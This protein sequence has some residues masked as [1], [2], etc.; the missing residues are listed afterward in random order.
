M[1]TETL[2]CLLPEMTLVIAAT[3][4]F[5]GGVFVSGR[6]LWSW[7]AVA[8]VLIAGWMLYRQYALLFWPDSSPVHTAIADVEAQRKAPNEPSPNYP[9]EPLLAVAVPGPLAIDL[10]SQYVRWLVLVVG[11]G[12]CSCQRGLRRTCRCPSMWERC[13]WPWWA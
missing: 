8:A 1:S 7:I 10:F 4:I 2:Y 5:V 11:L 9:V 6:A 13:C 3:L 12:L